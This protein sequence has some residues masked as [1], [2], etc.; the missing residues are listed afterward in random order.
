MLRRRSKP[1][2]Q[3]Q[4][5]GRAWEDREEERGEREEEAGTGWGSLIA[6]EGSHIACTCQE[7]CCRS[8][9]RLPQEARLRKAR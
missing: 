5:R 2:G 7:A 9:F 4:A 3:G 1:R 8:C 6:E